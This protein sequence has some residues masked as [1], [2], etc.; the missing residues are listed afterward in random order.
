MSEADVI[1]YFSYLF[2]SYLIGWG[3]GYLIHFFKKLMGYV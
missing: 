1:Q 2:G 3:S